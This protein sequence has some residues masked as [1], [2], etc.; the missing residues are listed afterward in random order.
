MSAFY[1][2]IDEILGAATDLTDMVPT[3][4]K[5]WFYDFVDEPVRLWDGRAT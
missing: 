5:C 2:Q 1:D 3:V 4:R